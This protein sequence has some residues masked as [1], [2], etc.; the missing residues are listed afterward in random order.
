MSKKIIS[1][2]FDG[3]CIILRFEGGGGVSIS[4]EGQSCCEHR[5]MTS[6]DNVG[7]LVGGEY[8]GFEVKDADYSDDDY[9]VHEIQ[10]LE[11]KSTNGSCVFETHN[12]H[13]GYYGGFW[14]VER[15]L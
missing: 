15:E 6:D 7:D 10:F 4:D 13:N 14:V 12:E 5:Y 2:D 3:D 1:A 8:L 11:V 9:G